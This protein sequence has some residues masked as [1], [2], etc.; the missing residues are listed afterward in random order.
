MVQDLLKTGT[1]IE[2]HTELNF[3]FAAR[4]DDFPQTIFPFQECISFLLLNTQKT[5]RTKGDI[6]ERQAANSMPLLIFNDMFLI[7]EIIL[8]KNSGIV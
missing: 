4:Y 1:G 2:M 5:P 8:L 7:R 3:A 6:L